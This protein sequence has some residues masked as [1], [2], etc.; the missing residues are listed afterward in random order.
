[1][2][3]GAECLRNSGEWG[4]GEPGRRQDSIGET[5]GRLA[6]GEVG[7]GVEQ[8]AEKSAEAGQGPGQGPGQA[9]RQGWD[10]GS[11]QRPMS[12]G[13]LY[14]GFAA[15]GVCMALPGSVLPALLAR[16]SLADSQAGLLFFLAWMGSSLGAIAVRLPVARALLIGD[17]LLSMAAL[18]MA[19]VAVLWPRSAFVWMMLFGVGLGMVM[20]ATSL[21]QATRQAYRRGAELNRLN[22]VWAVGASLC[23]TLAE[24]SLRV[25][26]VRSIFAGVG[27]FFAVQFAWVGLRERDPLQ[28]GAEKADAGRSRSGSLSL[29]PLPLV[30]LVF[31]PTGIE[32]SMGGWIAAYVQRTQHTI[33]TTVTAG[34]CFWIGLM[35]SRT[36]SS[37]LLAS[38]KGGRR[39]RLTTE[40]AVLRFG[41]GTVVA[42]MAALLLSGASLGVLPGVFLIGFGLGPVYPLVLAKALEYS[43]N[44]LIFFVAGL[45]SACLPW[46]TGVVSTGA[47]SLRIGLLVPSAASVLMLALGFAQLR[48][49]SHVVNAGL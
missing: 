18:G 15:T 26:D 47:S 12:Y 41:M 16:W 34:T 35:L 33:A 9:S 32:A 48:R 1:M 46:L 13:M 11:G 20:T 45:G 44:T 25:M 30:I 7:S 43:Q 42:G 6:G 49:P 40:G 21:L 2:G 4:R 29:W 38:Q 3:E 23:P 5:S 22:L 28:L 8:D 37:I 14:A 19:Y 17:G 39:P 36:L 27:V 24:H 31:L 10:E